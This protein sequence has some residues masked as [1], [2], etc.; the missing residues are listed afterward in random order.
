MDTAFI[1]VLIGLVVLAIQKVIVVGRKI[2]HSADPHFEQT[3]PDD[4]RFPEAARAF[5]EDVAAELAPRGFTPAAYLINPDSLPGVAG[6]I[7]V[8][9]RSQTRDLAAAMAICTPLTAGYAVEFACHFV[10]GAESDTNNASDPLMLSSAPLHEVCRF[11]GM[12]DLGALCR[13][14]EA[15]A[16]RRGTAKKPLPAPDQHAEYFRTQSLRQMHANVEVGL[17]RLDRNRQVF[18]YTLKGCLLRISRLLPIIKQIAVALLRRRA[19]RLLRELDLPP[20]YATIDYREKYRHLATT[21]AVP[22]ASDAPEQQPDEPTAAAAPSVCDNCGQT[23]VDAYYRAADRRVCQTCGQHAVAASTS[24][25]ARARRVFGGLGLGAVATVVAALIYFG[26]AALTGY[27]I[28]W[29]ALLTGF[30][31]GGGV[32]LGSGR[33]GG[34]G[35]QLMALL[36]TYYA[37]GMSYG[38]LGIHEYIKDPS[39]FES[40][41]ETETLPPDMHEAPAAPPLSLARRHHPRQPAPTAPQPPR[42]RPLPSRLRRSR[43]NLSRPPQSR[44]LCSWC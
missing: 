19:R 15:L 8:F 21:A 6:F 30:L 23:I 31:V 41:A 5:H 4:P 20:K 2:T 37:I 10:D 35:Y 42:Q 28:G 9:H 22:E 38:L 1:V 39:Q 24:G 33:R 26:V 14:H 36:L 12:A 13:A 25:G 7:A 40:F 18:Q 34:R 27:E 29:I 32:W 44:L 17:L 11:P 43:S 3:G 16:A